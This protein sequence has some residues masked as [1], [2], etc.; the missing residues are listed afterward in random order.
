[1][2]NAVRAGFLPRKGVSTEMTSLKY[3]ALLAT[4][5]LAFPL[6][7]FAK[8]RNEHTVTLSDP[9]QI[10]GTQLKAG[11]YRLEWQGTGA[12]TQVSF[13]QHGK[14]VATAPAT[15]KTNDDAVTQDAVVMSTTNNPRELK[16]IDFRHQKEALVFDQ[17]GM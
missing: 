1:M 4:L 12:G 5:A 17:S 16:E 7:S 2:L 10:G 3:I 8:D 9:V 11:D 6:S 13:I 15:L 14:T